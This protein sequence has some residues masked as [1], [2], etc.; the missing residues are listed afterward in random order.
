MAARRAGLD[1]GKWEKL[2]YGSGQ[3]DPKRSTPQEGSR[4]SVLLRKIMMLIQQ[5]PPR[6]ART[7]PSYAVSSS[8]WPSVIQQQL[9][10]PYRTWYLTNPVMS[11]YPRSQALLGGGSLRAMSTRSPDATNATNMINRAGVG[12][13]SSHLQEAIIRL[14]KS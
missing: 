8:S 1:A 2:R 10:G 11:N 14:L 12:L 4:E 5:V 13:I 3:G 9:H 7:S 6:P